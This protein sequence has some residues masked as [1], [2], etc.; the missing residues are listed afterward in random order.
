[1]VLKKIIA[2]EP[3]YTASH[4][5]WLD[6]LVEKSKHQYELLTLKGRHWKWRMKG[7]AI[8][9]AQMFN[10]LDYLPDAILVSDMLDLATF[11]T[12]TK[13]TTINIPVSLYFHENQ[14][15]YPFNNQNNKE[16]LERDLNYA[17]INY[18]SALAADKVYFNSNYH[19][20][21]FFDSLKPFL[22]RFPDNRNLSTINQIKDKAYVLPIAVDFSVIEA[23]RNDDKENEATIIWNHR[24][25][26]D[27]NPESFFKVLESIKQKQ[28]P[29][30]LIVL[31]EK[32]NKF[33]E[34]FTEAKSMFSKELIHFGY[35]NNKSDYYKLLWKADI[36]PV[37]SNQD[38]FGISAVEAI[39]ANCYPLLPNRLAFP[40]HVSAKYLYNSYKELVQNLEYLITN[41]K[42]VRSFNYSNMVKKYDWK[43]LISLYDKSI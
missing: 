5:Q 6:N 7:G 20:N 24:W 12:L 26:H 19:K 2:I 16:Q 35:V 14:L 38:F 21:I 30:K 31:G 10:D 34:V 32:F 36:L 39:Y 3:F 13:K 9:L 18:T 37:T 42:Q 17:Y 25:E 40:E 4:K 23:N 22:S 28:I 43:N 33:P 29:F 15:T 8:T 1:M 11:L 27:K 41:I